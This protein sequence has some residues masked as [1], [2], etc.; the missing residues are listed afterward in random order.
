VHLLGAEVEA[1]YMP[2]FELLV[3]LLPS[4]T[5]LAIHMIG[6]EISPRLEPSHRGMYFVSPERG[7]EVLLS[8]TS[9][10]YTPEHYSGS[11]MTKESGGSLPFGKGTPD[12]VII[13][14][15]NLLGHESWVESIKLLVD[16]GQKTLVTEPMEQGIEA[17]AR[18]LPALGAQL[19]IEPTPNPFKQPVY[20]YKKDTNLPG[21]S[22]AFIS[23]FGF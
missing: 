13:L 7:T 8:L 12:V 10:V 16:E 4:K 5:R 22:N 23:G 21:W 15:G 14:N 1:D 3:G 6:P 20:Q 9:S 19:S 2:A 11:V 17:I 18:N